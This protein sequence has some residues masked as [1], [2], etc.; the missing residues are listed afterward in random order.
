MER[1]KRPLRILVGVLFIVVGTLHFA[2]VEL[3]VRLTPPWV[4]VP[5]LW[6]LLSGVLELL[7]GIGLLLRPVRRAAAYGLALLM[8]VSLPVSVSVLVNPAAV[9][10]AWVP[11]LVL[12]WRLA[13][14]VALITLLVWFA[15][16]ER[17][18]A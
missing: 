7:G 18:H 1:V 16:D 10:L 4:P 5:V 6:V 3:Y 9:G 17:V 12:L 11:P 8:A 2:L 14:Q 13:L 15:E